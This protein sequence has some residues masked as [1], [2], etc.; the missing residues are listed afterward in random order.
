M[1]LFKKLLSK[2][3]KKTDSSQPGLTCKPRDQ[4]NMIKITS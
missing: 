2:K 3:E 4:N 1:K